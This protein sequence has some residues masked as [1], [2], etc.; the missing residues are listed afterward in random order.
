LL[1]RRGLDAAGDAEFARYERTRQDFSVVICDLDHFKRLNDTF[2]H[3]GGDAVLRQTA[4]LFEQFMRQTDVLARV[5][6][7]EFVLI[8]PWATLEGARELV[9]RLR[10]TMERHEF[11]PMGPE[12]MTHARMTASFG[13]TSTG[14]RSG[15]SWPQ[16]YQ[17]AD[18]ALYAAKNS[19]RNRAEVFQPERDGVAMQIG[20]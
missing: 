20:Q 6:G 12:S 17:E 16:L 1:N 9:E 5:G 15:V 2:G 19:G 7:E 3:T 8:L 14:G 18:L 10:S 11:L 4:V 13:I